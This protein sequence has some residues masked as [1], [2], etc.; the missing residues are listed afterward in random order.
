MWSHIFVELLFW[1]IF[2]FCKFTDGS[3][4]NNICSSECSCDC[5]RGKSFRFHW[6]VLAVCFVTLEAVK[7]IGP[8]TP[9]IFGPMIFTVNDS[10]IILLNLVWFLCWL[11]SS[12]RTWPC[13][14][15]VRICVHYDVWPVDCFLGLLC[16]FH[17]LLQAKVVNEIVRKMQ[18]FK[19]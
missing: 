18:K 3:F 11:T 7:I 13:F 19:E 1:T 5:G 6:Q 16:C 15:K 14:S 10:N 9:V 8:M 4:G 17:F 2:V 12:N